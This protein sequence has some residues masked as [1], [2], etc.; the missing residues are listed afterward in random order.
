MFLIDCREIKR[1][2]EK[3]DEGTRGFMRW[4]KWDD[5]PLQYDTS[6][7]ASGGVTGTM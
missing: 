3:S 5:G 4:E 7:S 1:E 2:K 6:G